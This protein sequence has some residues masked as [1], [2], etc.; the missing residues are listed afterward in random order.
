ML[1]VDDYG[2]DE[3]EM[4]QTSKPVPIMPPP[5]QIPKKRTAK[6]AF[7]LPKLTKDD[8][9]FDDQQQ[10]ADKKPRTRAP[11]KSSLLGML[12]APKNSPAASTLGA[13]TKA[14]L[15]TPHKDDNERED[16]G[17]QSTM[18]KPSSLSMKQAR[19]KPPGKQSEEPNGNFF[20]IA[21][22]STS[23]KIPPLRGTPSSSVS[24]A[25]APSVSD[26][27]PPEPTAEDEY[28][29]YYQLPS[30]RWAQYDPAYYTSFWKR[31]QEEWEKAYAKA[32][33]GFENADNLAENI[34]AAD[35]IDHGRKLREEKMALTKNA[36]VVKEKPNMNIPVC[37]FIYCLSIYH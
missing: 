20:S 35:Q 30:G 25:S 34:S 36:G 7:E 23:G 33:K 31:K 24:V 13:G 9:A 16:E 4:A 27:E 29:G 11:G 12:P 3:E 10:E 14:A 5:A 17:S 28:P 19:D 15:H 32:E 1:G 37:I 26:Y 8:E 6:V 18:F 21:S 22:T 2:S